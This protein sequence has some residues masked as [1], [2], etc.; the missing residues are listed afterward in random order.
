MQN[1]FVGIGS[2]VTI[3]DKDLEE[4]NTYRI[5]SGNKEAEEDLFFNSALGK[6]LM[7]H[8]VSDVVIVKA[9]QEYEVE[10]LEID[11]SNVVIPP[12]PPPKGVLVRDINKTY[13]TR[14]QAIYD[15]FCKKFGWDCTKSYL[16]G[17]QQIL[18]AE[19]ASPEGYSPWFLPH[20]NW[21]ETK[22]GN[23]FN[24]IRGDV[25]EEMWVEEQPR[26]H[27]DKTTRITFVKKKSGEYVFYGLY[28]PIKVEEKKI[29]EDIIDRNGVVLKKAGEKVWFKTYKLI[30][31]QYPQ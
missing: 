16:F 18:Y 25:I 14:A 10:I 20:S 6:A 4:K 24:T 31:S 12:P 29:S 9:E 19:K 8:K 7:K 27:Y 17:R 3:W 13:G 5:I 22:G 2:I 21:T 28:N 23:W 26:M 11:N 1:I 30:S 15:D